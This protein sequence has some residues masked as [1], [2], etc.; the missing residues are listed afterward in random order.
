MQRSGYLTSRFVVSPHPSRPPF[1]SVV[2]PPIEEVFTFFY[3]CDQTE[4][5][6]AVLEG[7]FRA[8]LSSQPLFPPFRDVGFYSRGFAN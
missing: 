4:L 1:G 2:L 6:W 8:R 7:R 5:S 3:R